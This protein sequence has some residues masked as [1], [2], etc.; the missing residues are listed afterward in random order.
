[1]G[2]LNLKFTAYHIDN[3]T[4]KIMVDVASGISVVVM[5][6]RTILTYG[7]SVIS[8]AQSLSLNHNVQISSRDWCTMVVWRAQ[9][10]TSHLARI[11]MIRF[12]RLMPA[13]VNIPKQRYQIQYENLPAKQIL[14]NINR[15]KMLV[16]NPKH[17]VSG[18]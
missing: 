7:G 4:C 11:T 9:H 2:S 8:L 13:R 1:M 12:K 5:V 6:S 3:S 10:T 14:Q 16:S 17:N 15:H 18:R